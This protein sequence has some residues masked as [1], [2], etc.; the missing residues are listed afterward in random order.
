MHDVNE[1]TLAW[2]DEHLHVAGEIEQLQPGGEYAD[3]RFALVAEEPP[4]G[5]NEPR[6]WI[7]RVSPDLGDVCEHHD[8]ANGMPR[9]VIDLARPPVT[10]RIPVELVARPGQAGHALELEAGTV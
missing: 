5:V 8:W 4:D 2:I 1:D 9:Y 10:A 6:L 7:A 3:C